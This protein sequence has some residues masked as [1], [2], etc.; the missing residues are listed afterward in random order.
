M[1]VEHVWSTPMLAGARDHAV[2]WRV[3]HGPERTPGYWRVVGTP[4]VGGVCVAPDVLEAFAARAR[5]G[6]RHGAF[7]TPEGILPPDE[8]R[9]VL[10]GL[11][12]AHAGERWVRG[13]RR[14][15]A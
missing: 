8:A 6:A 13:R 2:L 3:L 12:Y 1:G 4:L 10:A 5:E 14:V 9:A 11:G 7:T 15:H